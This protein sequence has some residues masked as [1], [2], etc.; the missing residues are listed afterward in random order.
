[1]C[2]MRSWPLPGDGKHT[3]HPPRHP[4][5]ET[6]VRGRALHCAVQVNSSAVAP[7]VWFP[8]V[9]VPL[10][11]SFVQHPGVGEGGLPRLLGLLLV[12]VHGA[13]VHVAQQIQQVAHQ[14]ALARVHVAWNEENNA[15]SP[16]GR[17]AKRKQTGE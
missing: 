6:A 4:A 2:R 12:L 14:R 5:E 3:F 15:R 8:S 1:M 9:P 10:L 13:L 17:R 16:S 7:S 11:A